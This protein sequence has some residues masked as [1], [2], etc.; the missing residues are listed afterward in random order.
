MVGFSAL[1]AIAA[2]F[3]V[4]VQRGFQTKS[5]TES[6]APPFVPPVYGIYGEERFVTLPLLLEE[7]AAQGTLS[8]EQQERVNEFKKRVLARVVSQIPLNDSERSI[9]SATV[10]LSPKAGEG[11]FIVADQRIIQFTPDEL[12]FIMEALKK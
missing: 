5:E 7:A 11:G 10:S 3:F 2:F 12:R 4:S 6:A 8:V 9:I 1:A